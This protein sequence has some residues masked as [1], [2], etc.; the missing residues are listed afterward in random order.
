MTGSTQQPFTNET[1]QQL[2]QLPLMGE[3]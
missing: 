1:T 2:V 3:L